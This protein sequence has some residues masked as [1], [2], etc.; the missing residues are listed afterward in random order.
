MLSVD[1][2]NIDGPPLAVEC[3][4]KFKSDLGG[5]VTSV[6]V[7]VCVCVY[8]CMYVCMYVCV[9]VGNVVRAPQKVRRTSF[10]QSLRIK[11]HINGRAFYLLGKYHQCG[12]EGSGGYSFSL[13]RGPV[14]RRLVFL[15]FPFVVLFVCSA[16]SVGVVVHNL[17]L[18]E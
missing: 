9:Y 13:K 4:R 15:G 5:E 2:S 18:N 10:I 3:I 1:H 17:F 11:C 14:F 12:G 7:C 6:C 8:V 16:G